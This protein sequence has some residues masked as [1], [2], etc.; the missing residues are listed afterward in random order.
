MS[1]VFVYPKDDLAEMLQL[2]RAE[3]REILTTHEHFFQES[4]D[5]FLQWA[6]SEERY[7]F[8][9]IV[10]KSRQMQ[11]VFQLIRR[12][13]DTDITVLVNGDTGTGK[14]MVARAIH[15]GS[16]RTDAAFIPVNC[17]AI[18]ETLLESELFG[19]T[20]GAFTG[21]DSDR[22][23]LLQEATG[24]TVFLDEIGDTTQMFQVKLLRALQ[25]REVMPLGSSKRIPIDVR[26]IAATSKNLEKEIE[27]GNFRSDLYYRI[28]VVKIPLPRLRDR[29]TDILPLARYFIRKYN[30]RMGK[31]VQSISPEVADLLIQYPWRG[32]VRE[33]ENVI[34]RAVALCLGYEIQ[35]VDL[36]DHLQDVRQ[37]ETEPGSDGE[38]KT[39]EQ[40]EQ[41]YITQLL[42]EFQGNYA[43][44]AN[45]LGIGRTTLWR[46][47]K[48]YGLEREE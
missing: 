13:A 29:T 10:G 31:K 15:M 37:A 44:V 8:H 2:T 26:I 35:P 47:M 46:K 16:P 25:E 48:K 14:E 34:E 19:H 42:R 9:G 36:P 21:A 30:K 20:R 40:V 17:G 33:L 3:R 41:E 5:T 11:Q 23:G 43:E 45:K 7:T 27:R 39:L 18:P 38:I 1:S 32:N 28:N 6:E 22:T 4:V 12:V 24:G